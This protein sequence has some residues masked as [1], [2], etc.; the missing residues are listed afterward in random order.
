MAYFPATADTRLS[1][2]SATPST[3]YS[4]TAQR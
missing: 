2:D 3:I 1:D 4:A